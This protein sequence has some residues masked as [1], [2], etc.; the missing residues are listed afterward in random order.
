MERDPKPL[1]TQSGP[2]REQK[3]RSTM[4]RRPRS[5]VDH[6]VRPPPHPASDVQSLSAITSA[7]G[8]VRLRSPSR[9][10][11]DTGASHFPLFVFGHCDPRTKGLGRR[12]IGVENNATRLLSA[13][14]AQVPDVHRA[15]GYLHTPQ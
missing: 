12:A 13:A 6:L 14:S 2:S 5:C 4:L 15:R 7:L 10:Q 9:M 8:P 1:Q 3:R 11:L